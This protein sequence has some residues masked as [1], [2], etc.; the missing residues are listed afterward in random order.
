M[1]KQKRKEDNLINS[2]QEKQGDGLI[3]NE[4]IPVDYG[5]N[6]PIIIQVEEKDLKTLGLYEFTI[7]GRV[8]KD[9]KEIVCVELLSKHK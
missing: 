3:L 2:M 4:P 6:L 7:K 8:Y 5:E 9:Y 1:I